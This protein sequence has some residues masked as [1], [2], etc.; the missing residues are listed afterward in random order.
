MSD[1]STFSDYFMK[2]FSVTMEVLMVIF[3][4]LALIAGAIFVFGIPPYLCFLNGDKY[5]CI[6]AFLLWI[7]LITTVILPSFITIIQQIITPKLSEIS[8]WD[9]F[10]TRYSKNFEIIIIGFLY[11]IAI[12]MIGTIIILFFI[13]YYYIVKDGCQNYMCII[14]I[15]QV[16]IIIL[17]FGPA[18][19]Y[20]FYMKPLEVISV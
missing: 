12:V 10:T 20:A 6:T 8:Y 4:V 5:L 1:Q 18:L 2:G 17:L 11:F 15:V 7:S 19:I 3:V 13:P 16:S 9:D 14:G